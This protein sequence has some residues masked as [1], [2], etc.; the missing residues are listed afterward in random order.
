M[1]QDALLDQVIV[2]CLQE[3]GQILQ[4]AAVKLLIDPA[5]PFAFQFETRHRLAQDVAQPTWAQRQVFGI[6]G[7]TAQ[8]H[9]QALTQQEQRQAVAGLAAGRDFLQGHGLVHGVGIHQG[10]LGELQQTATAGAVD[11][12]FGFF[13]CARQCRTQTRHE[14]RLQAAALLM[15][16]SLDRQQAALHLITAGLFG[17]LEQLLLQLIQHLAQAAI[18]FVRTQIVQTF[19]HADLAG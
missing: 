18:E 6:E 13:G 10:K 4:H 19:Q 3:G 2:D 11:R 12:C 8:D 1:R 16:T 7:R 17:T 15:D 9:T 5:A 14:T